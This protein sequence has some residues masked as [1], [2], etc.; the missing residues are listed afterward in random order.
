MVIGGSVADDLLIRTHTRTHTHTHAHLLSLSQA[1]AEK[2]S[3]PAEVAASSSTASSSTLSTSTTTSTSVAAA[4][5]A[6]PRK[7]KAAGGSSSKKAGGAESDEED[8]EALKAENLRGY[9]VLADGRKTTYFNKELSEET[10]RLIGDIA[11]KKIDPAEAPA[12]AA[13]NGAGAGAGQQP[14]GS[15]WNH[16][17]TFEERNMTEWAKEKLKELLS[18]VSFVMPNVGAVVEVVKVKDLEGD[19]AVTFVRGKKKC[20]CLWP[21]VCCCCLVVVGSVVVLWI[22]DDGQASRQAVH[23]C[24]AK[25][26]STD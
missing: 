24:R 11:P 16:A 8:E 15:A 5:P 7:P 9:K 4:A 6:P 14:V 1:A 2:A 21:I 3:K 17:G 26:N 18:G 19:A 22:D 10:K 20:V 13:T 12:G 25:K 23:G